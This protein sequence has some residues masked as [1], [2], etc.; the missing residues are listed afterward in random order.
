MYQSADLCSLLFVIELLFCFD[1]P[2]LRGTYQEESGRGSAQNQKFVIQY[3]WNTS[4]NTPK[5]ETRINAVQN[6][7]IAIRVVRTGLRGSEHRMLG[8]SLLDLSNWSENL[9]H[10]AFVILERRSTE[11]SFTS[12]SSEVRY[13]GLAEDGSRLLHARLLRARQPE[14]QPRVRHDLDSQ[15]ERGH[16]AEPKRA[17]GIP[18]RKSVQSMANLHASS[19]VGRRSLLQCLALSER[20]SN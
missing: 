4:Q 20:T 3:A 8:D 7:A 13:H 19:T 15:H 14:R 17:T 12:Q 16:G 5:R 10:S 2:K 1:D 6:T 11:L 18:V 9:Y